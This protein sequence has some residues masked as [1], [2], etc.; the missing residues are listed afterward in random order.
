[1][2][3]GGPLRARRAGRHQRRCRAPGVSGPRTAAPA[4]ATARVPRPGT[5]STGPRGPRAPRR[6]APLPAKRGRTPGSLPAKA[7]LGDGLDARSGIRQ[8]SS[9]RVAWSSLLCSPLFVSIA[10]ANHV[11]PVSR[12][13]EARRREHS[14]H[15]WPTRPPQD[16]GA[17]ERP[18][19]PSA[20]LSSRRGRCAVQPERPDTLSA[21]IRTLGGWLGSGASFRR[22]T[23]PKWATSD[24]HEPM[25]S[26]PAPIAPR[27]PPSAP[28]VVSP[29]RV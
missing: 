19:T 6:D 27:T 17:Q 1:M 23:A 29:I 12:P 15:V 11:R 10:I 14:D 24:G 4:P 28:E 18:V 22:V 26:A 13:S 9:E 21:T 25:P 7:V 16:G 2:T 20:S 8:G 3:P 5:T